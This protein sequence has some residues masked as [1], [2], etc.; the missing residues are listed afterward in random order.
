MAK[1]GG[2]GCKESWKR[3]LCLD[4]NNEDIL[5]KKNSDYYL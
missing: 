3:E 4:P 1:F 2:E 5:G